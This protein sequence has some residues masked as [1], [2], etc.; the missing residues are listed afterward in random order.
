MGGNDIRNS[1][2]LARSWGAFQYKIAACRRG[3]N[4]DDLRTV[5]RQRHEKI[6]GMNLFIYLVRTNEVRGVHIGIARG[7]DQMF[8]E[9][10]LF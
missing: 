8:D 9:F 6:L 5:R 10:V 4:G 7:V 2:R 3:V 1:L